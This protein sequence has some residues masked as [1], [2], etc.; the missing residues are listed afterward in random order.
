MYKL[1]EFRH[2]TGLSQDNMARKL[3]VSVSMYQ[4]VERGAANPSIRFME[5]LKQVYPHA[6]IDVIFFSDVKT[7]PRT[8]KEI[9]A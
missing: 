5:K 6:S 9:K 8:V 1:Q 2:T 4:K 7:N 3:G